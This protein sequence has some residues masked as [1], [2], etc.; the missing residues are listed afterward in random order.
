L[1]FQTFALLAN[2]YGWDDT[3]VRELT[4]NK[5]WAYAQE[6]THRRVESQLNAIEATMFHLIPPDK[7]QQKLDFYTSLLHK[8]TAKEI[9]RDKKA[10]RKK[11]K[12]LGL[13]KR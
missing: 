12:M 4:I 7:Q 8:K 5:F 1:I 10:Q 3:Q 9:K 6:A 2:T 11:L 13:L